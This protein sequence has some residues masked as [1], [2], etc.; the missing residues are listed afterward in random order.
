MNCGA[1]LKGCKCEYCGTEY[2]F[3]DIIRF[4]YQIAEIP[5]ETLSA[6]ITVPDYILLREK[7]EDFVKHFVK[8]RIA[9]ELGE[10][11]EDYMEIEAWFD[12]ARLE[13]VFGA[14]VKVGVIK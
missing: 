12:P 7:P 11:L 14:R 8:P 2:D 13:H 1:P 6:Q 5:L 3:D 4:E 10:R 9:R